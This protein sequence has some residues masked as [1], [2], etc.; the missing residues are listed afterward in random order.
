[1]TAVRPVTAVIVS[2]QAK[3][4][5]EAC[6]SSLE[7]QA[8]IGRIVVVDNA[9]TDGTVAW[10]LSR[11]GI[12]V[13]ANPGNE[14]FA[15]AA[16]MGGRLAETPYVLLLNC[17]VEVPPGALDPLVKQ[18][19]GNSQAAAASARLLTASGVDQLGYKPGPARR[20]DWA[21]G[22]CLLLRRAAMDEVGW[23]DPRFFF[24]NEDVDLGIRLRRAGWRIYVVPDSAVLHHEGKSTDGVR[25]E[26]IVHGYRGGLY[27]VEK[28]YRWALRLARAAIR[29]EIRLRALGYQMKGNLTPKQ[30]AFLRALPA[31]L[32]L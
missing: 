21:P 11:G 9:S 20:V 22:A 4:F 25:H 26:T 14:G 23:F 32:T 16:N 12:E 10:L 18:L 13:L 5:L 19:D 1:M 7:A 24:Y 17:D 27:L 3:A 15:A 31:L 6:L 30:E 29:V 8:A 28:H 2:Y